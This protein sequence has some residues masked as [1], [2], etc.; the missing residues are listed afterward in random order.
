MKRR[1]NGLEPAAT[2]S[3]SACE[4]ISIAWV[5]QRFTIWAINR[6][7]LRNVARSVAWNHSLG[8]LRVKNEIVAVLLLPIAVWR[9]NVL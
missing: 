9:A 2:S 6:I 5:H 4:A 1:R 3:L 8:P 7:C